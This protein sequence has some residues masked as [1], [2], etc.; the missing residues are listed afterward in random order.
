MI[1]KNVSPEMDYLRDGAGNTITNLSKQ[2]PSSAQLHAWSSSPI[3][4]KR[5][6][7]DLCFSELPLYNS[8]AIL[9]IPLK[10]N[11]NG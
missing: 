11:R 1:K 9:K 3:T 8:F 5:L 4:L 10:I 6:R 2:Q 7:R